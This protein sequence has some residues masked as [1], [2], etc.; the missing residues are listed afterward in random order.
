MD[1]IYFGIRNNNQR[2]SLQKRMLTRN[3]ALS[4]EMH[5]LLKMQILA[6]PEKERAA[7]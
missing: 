2:V 4:Q 1:E 3:E 5:Y 7:F 6:I